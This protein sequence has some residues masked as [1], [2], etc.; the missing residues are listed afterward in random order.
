MLLLGWEQTS[1]L[2]IPLKYVRFA[3]FVE[4]IIIAHNTPIIPP[5][6]KA[7][8]KYSGEAQLFEVLQIK[9]AITIIG[10]IT[11]VAMF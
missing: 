1:W 11:K 3:I 10:K 5:I 4:S 9:S 8:N 6:I 2:L 7:V